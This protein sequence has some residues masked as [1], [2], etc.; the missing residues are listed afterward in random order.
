MDASYLLLSDVDWLHCFHCS[1]MIIPRVTQLLECQPQE[2]CR[3][4]LDLPLPEV[5]VSA[6]PGL[7][8]GLLPPP[9]PLQESL[10]LASVSGLLLLSQPACAYK[11]LRKQ[12]GFWCSG[13]ARP[14]GKSLPAAGL[15]ALPTGM[16]R[17]D[18]RQAKGP[19]RRQQRAGRFLTFV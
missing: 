10:H 11:H 7:G 12:T 3:C 14:D 15:L 9:H 17:P 18:C 6:G 4:W 16:C 1:V 8:I 2:L 13:T 19:P 5:L